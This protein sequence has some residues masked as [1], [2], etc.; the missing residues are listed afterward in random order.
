MRCLHA[1]IRDDDPSMQCLLRALAEAP[2]R[3][4]LI[5][6]AWQVSR[7]LTVRLVAAVLAARACRP[8]AWPR[9]PR[10]GGPIRSKGVATRQRTSLVGL[11]RGQRRIGRCPQG[12]AIPQVAP[13]AEA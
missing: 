3:T 13:L 7:V 10:C 6:A 12:C 9:G 5:L 4:A 8:T 11:L 1:S 2:S